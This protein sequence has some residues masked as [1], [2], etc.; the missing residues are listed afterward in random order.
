[1]STT[2]EPMT[3]TEATPTELPFSDVAPG[4]VLEVSGNGLVV[5][6]EH[7][8]QLAQHLRDHEGYDYLS[9]VTSVDWPEYFEV[10]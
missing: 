6:A 1:M 9:M 5:S 10:V 3:Q 2:A 4:A 8:L 7:L